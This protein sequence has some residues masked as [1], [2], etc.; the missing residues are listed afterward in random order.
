MPKGFWISTT[1]ALAALWVLTFAAALHSQREAALW[2]TKVAEQQ[3]SVAT[4]T[5]AA[6]AKMTEPVRE[7]A[8]ITVTPIRENERCMDG[9]RFRKEGNTWTNIG[10]C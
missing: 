3:A 2:K 10:T 1:W 9:V 6:A 5:G 7:I 4:P 8:P